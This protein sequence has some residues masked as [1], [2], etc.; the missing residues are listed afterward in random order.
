MSEKSRSSH[1]KKESR[2]E[3]PRIFKFATSCN[4]E[5]MH[6]VTLRPAEGLSKLQ[7]L[8]QTK[9]KKVDYGLG[10]GAFPYGPSLITYMDA[11]GEQISMTTDEDFLECVAIAK[12]SN[13][14]VACLTVFQ[15]QIPKTLIIMGP[16]ILALVATIILFLISEYATEMM[17]V[18]F[19]SFS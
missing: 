8:I 15:Y 4:D 7:K 5:I 6:K 11:N 12:D 1:S 17:G 14:R 10:G 16:P 2:N 18:K 9:L 3:K 13:S 19:C